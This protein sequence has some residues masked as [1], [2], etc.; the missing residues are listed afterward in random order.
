MVGTYAD[1]TLSYE[2]KSMKLSELVE[3]QK[4]AFFS[5][6]RVTPFE[7]IKYLLRRI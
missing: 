2:D 5:I 4:P 3:P 7:L 6:T 1:H